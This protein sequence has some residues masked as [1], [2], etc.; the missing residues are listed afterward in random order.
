MLPNAGEAITEVQIRLPVGDISDGHYQ[1][2]SW[3][4]GL[5]GSIDEPSAPDVTKKKEG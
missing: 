4:L 5:N 1:S 3:S 2:R